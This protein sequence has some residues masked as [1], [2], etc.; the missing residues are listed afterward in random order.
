MNDVLRR[1]MALLKQYPEIMEQII[2]LACTQ[3]EML[4]KADGEGL[5]NIVKKQEE[6]VLQLAGLEYSRQELQACL[7]KAY[8]PAAGVTLSGLLPFVSSEIRA[9][10]EEFLICFNKRVRKLHEINQD[11]RV[12]ILYALQ[13]TNRVL[14]M[15]GPAGKEVTYQGKG[16]LKE[17]REAASLRLNKVV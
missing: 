9:E 4:K 6:L 13:F 12:L 2:S 17:K 11:N 1:L 15:V 8:G 14:S 7:E 3:T 5:F 10:I 16:E